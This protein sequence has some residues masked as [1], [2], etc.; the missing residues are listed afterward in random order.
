M[1]TRMGLLNGVAPLW[2]KDAGGDAA[3]ANGENSDSSGASADGDKG[4]EEP[5][6]SDAEKSAAAGD[7]GDAA[8]GDQAEADGATPPSPKPQPEPEAKPTDKWKDDRI[9]MLTK[10]LAKATAKPAP[11]PTPKPP[12]AQPTEADLDALVESRAEQK[13]RLEAF[14]S[15]ANAARKAGDGTFGKAFGE[16]VNTIVNEVIGGDADELAA[17]NQFLVTAMDVTS[18]DDNKDASLANLLYQVG[19]DP[20]ELY[21]L[22]HLPQAKMIKELIKIGAADTPAPSAAPKPIT[23]IGGN[24]GAAHTGI[25][26]DDPERADTLTTTQ[27]MERRNKQAEANRA[28]R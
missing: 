18:D 4:G 9:A 19:G 6:S 15:R 2:A 16:R 14:N 10:R 12:G 24:K 3:P 25:S 8:S 1:V 5:S 11:A 21:R 17:Y 23:P 27:W 13:N 26:P 20:G 22:M 7:E 28:R